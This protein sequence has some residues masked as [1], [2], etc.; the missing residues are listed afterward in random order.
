MT[1]RAKWAFVTKED[2]DKYIGENSGTAVKFER[3]FKAA[4][5]D[6]DADTK[7]IQKRRKIRRM[8]KNQ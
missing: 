7:M 3:V 8:Q 2:A 4:Y 1:K 6:M 5:E